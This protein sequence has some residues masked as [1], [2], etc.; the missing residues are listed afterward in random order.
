MTSGARAAAAW[1]VGLTVVWV[2]LQGDLSAANVIG[3]ALAALV[4]LVAVPVAAPDRRHRVH[5]LGLVRFLA[6]VGWSLVTSSATVAR[7]VVAPRPERLR[8]GFV[9]IELPGA[10][11]L[12]ATMVAN[13][14]SLTPGTLTVTA[15]VDDDG[16]VLHV[17]V[18][19]LADVDAY[20][21][22]VVD[23]QRRA[24]AAVSPRTEVAR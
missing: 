6:F 1:V 3:G 24:T 19:G 2:L 23:L 12:V 15:S 21:A 20:R 14:I 5:P 17:H 16:A 22:E 18:L 4:V 7:T 10:T 8:A 9:R 11:Q 13:A